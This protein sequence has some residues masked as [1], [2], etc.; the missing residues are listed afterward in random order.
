MNF[1][2]SECIATM[3]GMCTLLDMSVQELTIDRVIKQL[4]LTHSP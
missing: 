1:R 4:Y 2:R 3:N